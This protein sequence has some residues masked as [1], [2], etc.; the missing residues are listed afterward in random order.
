MA[1]KFWENLKQLNPS[2]SVIVAPP[3]SKGQPVIQ[4]KAAG[5]SA[6]VNKPVNKD[7]LAETL[8]FVLKGESSWN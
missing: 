3:I 6:M 2:V 1:W 4:V 8:D 5:A 7:E